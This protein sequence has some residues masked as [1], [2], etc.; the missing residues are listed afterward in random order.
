MEGSLIVSPTTKLEGKFEKFSMTPIG[1]IKQITI[2]PVSSNE[3]DQKLILVLKSGK[4]LPIPSQTHFNVLESYFKVVRLI[5]KIPYDSL[6]D[7]ILSVPEEWLLPLL[8]S[9]SSL[10]SSNDET[11]LLTHPRKIIIK[12]PNFGKY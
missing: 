10:P 4:S 6:L 2:D 8:N 7:Q 11:L 5:G 9:M 12:D 1:P 3:I